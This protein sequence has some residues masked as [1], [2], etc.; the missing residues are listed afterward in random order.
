MTGPRLRDSRDPV[1]LPRQTVLI[2][3]GRIVA[4]GPVDSTLVP[5]D[6]IRIDSRSYFITPGLVDAHVHSLR[7]ESS[8]DLPLYLANGITTVRNMYGE[9]YHVRWRQEIATGA[10]LGPRLVT[11]SAF[12]DG[13]TTPEQARIFVRQARL[14][15]YD[16]VKVHLPLQPSVYEAITAAARVEKIPVVGH[17]PGRGLGVAAAVRA[18]QRTIEHAE[19]IMQVETNEQ[20]PADADI[21]RIVSQ[22]RGSGICVTPTLVTFDHVIRMTEQY[23]KLHGLLSQPTMQYV[24]PDLRSEWAP[25][26]NEYVMRWRGH[27]AELP[28]ALAKFRRQYSW[29]RRLVGA[30]AAADVPILAGTDASV[31][32]VIPGFS[33]HEEL[34]LLVEA[35]LS[36][37]G[38][39]R[40]ASAD[41]AFCF[42]RPGEFGAVQTGMSADLLLLNQNPLVDIAA[43]A[44]PVGV[45][46]AGRWLPSDTLSRMLAR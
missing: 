12:A 44:H 14:D 33:L 9:P 22:L 30:L 28:N 10:R 29:M 17:A 11:T 8:A 34:R 32:T 18:G 3:S 1:V 15:G 23:P 40:A 19:S 4:V 36:P 16:A 38:A 2:R 6:A 5:A 20:D 45:V 41:A 39:L 42:G 43:V 25:T 37:Y 21:P 31:A 35:G 46:V 26:H 24:R 13:L 7:R 27:E